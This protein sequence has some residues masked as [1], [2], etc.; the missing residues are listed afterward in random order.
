MLKP[1]VSLPV[2]LATAAVVY[3]VYQAAL[4]PVAD[5][6]T[7]DRSHPDVQAAERTASWFSAAV[8]SG[9]SLLAKDPTIFVIGSSAV[10][11]L[12]WWYRHSDQVIPELSKA[13]PNYAR[14]M[15]FNE[16]GPTPPAAAQPDGAPVAEYSA[17]GGF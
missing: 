6:R 7:A 13:V 10:I 14:D 3:G 8:V 17:D 5:V 9:I 1:E 16:P 15:V 2:G 11:A 4:P 12:A